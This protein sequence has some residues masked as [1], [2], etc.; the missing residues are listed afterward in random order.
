[1]E[2]VTRGVDKTPLSRIIGSSKK[3]S[4]LRGGIVKAILP[5]FLP[6]FLACLNG[7]RIRSPLVQKGF[8]EIVELIASLAFCKKEHKA[9]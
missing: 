3:P 8:G 6:L 1:M 5:Y 2:S 4:G 7:F 9:L